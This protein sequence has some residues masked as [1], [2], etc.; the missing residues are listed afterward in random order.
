MASKHGKRIVCGDD[1][2]EMTQA[3]FA[4]AK[5]LKAEMPDVVEV[6]KRGR[7]RPEVSVRAFE[8]Q[9]AAPVRE[10]FIK[11]NRLLS[12]PNMTPKRGSARI[13]ESY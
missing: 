11:V 1:I 8:E 10:L 3:D 4:A 2:P 12:P 13:C 5:S 7:G 6:M 9:D